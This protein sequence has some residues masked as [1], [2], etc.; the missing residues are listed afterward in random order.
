M[1]GERVA[2]SGHAPHTVLISSATPGGNTGAEI[3][4]CNSKNNKAPRIIAKP[5]CVP[6]EREREVYPVT[7]Q[8]PHPPN[9]SSQPINSQ[10]PWDLNTPC[11]T[12]AP[13]R[14][15]RSKPPMTR[16]PQRASLLKKV[17]IP[18]AR[19]SEGAGAPRET[20]HRKPTGASQAESSYHPFKDQRTALTQQ[21]PH[22]PTYRPQ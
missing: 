18:H 7:P 20:A 17:R 21:L 3:A 22:P 16:L 1:A 4:T 9:L 19:Y 10:P 6:R 8:C 11:S 5:P 14:P 15:H 13:R 2:C 12:P